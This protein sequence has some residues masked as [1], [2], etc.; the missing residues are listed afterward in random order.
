MLREPLFD[1]FMNIYIKSKDRASIL[2][3]INMLQRTFISIL[4]PIVG[5][6]S[7]ISVYHAVGIISL[8]TFIFAIIGKVDE[9]HLE[10][11][12]V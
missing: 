7:D 9:S 11:S 6:L 12:I 3:A 10:K 8:L 4:Y 2:S 5:L 1:H